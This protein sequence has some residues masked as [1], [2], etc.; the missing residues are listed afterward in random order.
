MRLKIWAK[1]FGKGAAVVGIGAAISASA[2]AYTQASAFDASA[3]KVWSIRPVELSR[4]TD[5]AVIARGKHLAEAVA[6]CATA[7][8]HGADLGGGQIA[9]IGP[10]GTFTAPNITSAGIGA[11]YSDAELARL[12]RHG[13]KKDGRSVVFMP[14]SDFSW[15][16]DSDVVAL[17]SFV[18]SMPA[19]ERANGPMK[20]KLLG[21]ILDRRGQ[22][23]LVQAER[24]DHDE[25]GHAPPPS[26][27]VEYGAYLGRLCKGCH[28]PGLSGGP[29]PGAPPGMPIPKN[30]TPDAT[31]LGSWS[32]DDFLRALEKGESKDGRKLD[33]MMP[34]ET[35]GKMDDT[36]K[37]AL[38]AY[39]RTAPP[40]AF[41]NR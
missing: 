8:C 30:L 28:G 12:I 10:V 6:P 34:S 22:F 11:A 40:R 15:L 26:A 13:V 31:G 24:I 38:F 33:S 35:F 1:R 17:V 20:V 29:I 5:A 36:E 32:Y 19:V 18:R 21:K 14:A 2:Y 39:L 41:G 4:S 37:H 27:T 25:A 3:E 23:P 16:S 7:H 9:D